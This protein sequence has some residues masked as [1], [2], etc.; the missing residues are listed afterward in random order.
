[1]LLLRVPSVRL[2]RLDP[3]VTPAQLVPRDRLVRLVPQA[4]RVLPVQLVRLDRRVTLARWSSGP[5]GPVGPMGPAVPTGPQGEAGI[6]GTPNT[7]L[8][9]RVIDNASMTQ[10]VVDA[11]TPGTSVVRLLSNGTVTGYE[12]SFDNPR[13]P[14]AGCDVSHCVYVGAFDYRATGFFSPP[15]VAGTPGDVTSLDLA[16]PSKSSGP[17]GFSILV[18]CP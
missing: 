13:C 17:T 5:A 4:P 7:V 2:V 11:G 3:R 10:P 15:S 1:M 6:P 16:L 9:V 8:A 12:V 14:T 18:T